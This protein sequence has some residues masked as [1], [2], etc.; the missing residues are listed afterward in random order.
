MV[1]HKPSQRA[2]ICDFNTH[3]TGRYTLPATLHFSVLN[4]SEIT[5]PLLMITGLVYLLQYTHKSRV[6]WAPVITRCRKAV[7]AAFSITQTETQRSSC[8]RN[9]TE[10]E[11]GPRE[12][13]FC[14]H[15]IIKNSQN[16]RK[17]I[18]VKMF[19]ETIRT[20]PAS[21]EYGKKKKKEKEEKSNCNPLSMG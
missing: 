4:T 3:S 9:G 13:N 17:E 18:R 1:K 2:Y 12:I 10:N 19:N 8:T 6:L 11:K 7:R 21:H 20:R 5:K 14:S 15:Q 16:A